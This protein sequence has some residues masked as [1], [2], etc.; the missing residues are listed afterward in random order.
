MKRYVR[1][2]C[3]AMAIGLLGSG[4]AFAKAWTWYIVSTNVVQGSPGYLDVTIGIKANS[5]GDVG[6]LGNNTIR[7]TM[8]V[9]LYDY[10]AVPTPHNP[11]F[12]A[13][14]LGGSY[15]MTLT[16]PSGA[17]NW[18]RNCTY[19]GG[20]GFGATVSEAGLAVCTIRFYILDPNGMSNVTLGSLNQTYDDSNL[21]PASS[22]TYNN[23]GGD[24]LL[25]ITLASFTAKIN[26]SGPG[27]KLEWR[28]LSEVNN[29][30]FYV[31]RR[32]EGDSL[33]AEI[34]NSFVAGHGTTVQPQQYGY[35]DNTV[36]KVG[37]YYY[38]LRQVDLD[39]TQHFSSGSGV[40]IEVA[41]LSVKEAAPI[42]F[43]L[44]Q[45][46]PNPFN[47][48]TEIKFSVES[49]GRAVVKIYNISGQ[50]VATVF[51]DVA[52]AGQYYR[53]RL[54]GNGL[55]TGVYFYRLQSGKKSDLKK[56]LLLK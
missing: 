18:Q 16:N 40:S 54:D 15:S 50:E 49:T 52:E 32:L 12:Q 17:N 3:I 14:L 31:Q 42:E 26:P 41:L 55:A 5:A 11:E 36:S 28:T 35:V 1:L 27:V 44:Q 34:E 56:M 19:G 13:N 47:P 46:Y 53:L 30:G 24:V 38:R 25:P 37:Q 2:V 9:G 29:Y 48:Q 10:N 33:F 6:K 4:E 22:L 43:K 8:S 51:D 39:G 21:P 45:N 23:T 7:G 20:A